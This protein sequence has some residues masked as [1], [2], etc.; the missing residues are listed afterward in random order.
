MLRILLN[1]ALRSMIECR[2][3]D[4]QRSGSCF[5]LAKR[6]QLAEGKFNNHA[7]VRS[8]YRQNVSGINKVPEIYGCFI[9]FRDPNTSSHAAPENRA[10]P[11]LSHIAS[12]QR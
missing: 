3:T 12:Q 1:V 7:C 9:Y 4:I 8:F 10:S 5:Q 11:Y 2:M 6:L